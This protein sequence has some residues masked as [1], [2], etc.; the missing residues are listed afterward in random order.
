[1]VIFEHAPPSDQAKLR[2]LWDAAGLG[3]F[4]ELMGPGP[5]SG[6]GNVLFSAYSLYSAL[7]LFCAAA[8]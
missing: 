3:P 4:P 6:A 8:R 1:M 7:K 5:S 2:A